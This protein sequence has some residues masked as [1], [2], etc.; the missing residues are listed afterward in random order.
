MSFSDVYRRNVQRYRD[1]ISRLRA[2]YSREAQEKSRLSDRIVSEKRSA[3]YST[4]ESSIRMHMSAVARYEQDQARCD[5]K[6]ADISKRIA[7]AES[8]LARESQRLS[9]EE[10][11]DSR[12]QEEEHRRA[13]DALNRSVKANQTMIADVGAAVTELQQEKNKITVLFLASNPGE[14]DLLRLDE[15][16]RAIQEMIR[17]SD[18]RDSIR[19]VSRWAVRPWDLLQAINEERPTI[20]HFSGHGTDAGELVLQSDADQAKFVTPT[21][22][23][24]AIAT[25]NDS[26]RLVFFNACFSEEQAKSVVANIDA[27]IG[28]RVSISDDAARVFAAHFYSAIGFGKDMATAFKQGKAELILEGIPE[29]NTPVLYLREGLQGEQMRLLEEK[30]VL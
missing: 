20:I 12:R 13:M 17:K 26:V 30:G 27:A 3:S 21:A 2:A 24:T 6:M 28:M 18:Y 8:N 29:E 7:T 11:R 19:F 5:K 15:E 1:E 22:L 10:E 25:A 9:D 23:A 14:T 4:S 16:A